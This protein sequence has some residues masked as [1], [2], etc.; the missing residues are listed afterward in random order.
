MAKRF[1]F[2]LVCLKHFDLGRLVCSD[3]TLQTKPKRFSSSKPSK[4][5]VLVQSFSNCVVME[6]NMLRPVES[7]LHFAVSQKCT[8]CVCGEF[9]LPRS[10]RQSRLSVSLSTC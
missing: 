6:F 9:S 1:H 3:A 4:H 5:G 2:G 7:S 10:G 8:V